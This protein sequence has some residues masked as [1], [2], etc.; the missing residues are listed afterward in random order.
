MS[1]DL[2]VVRH[3]GSEL[4][5][6]I[7]DD[8]DRA[9]TEELA[10]YIVPPR[11]KIVQALSDDSLKEL[12]GEGALVAAPTN[13]VLAKVG[14]KVPFV[15]VLFWPSWLVWNPRNAGDLPM[16][17]EETRDP[18]SEIAAICRDPQR[19]N[20]V[21]CPEFPDKMLRYQEHLNYLVILPGV[22][23]HM[24]FALSFARTQHRA[25]SNLAALIR[26]RN[27][28][29]YAGGYTMHTVR[30]EN[31]EGRWFGFAIENAGWVEDP[32]L[33]QSLKEMHEEL[34]TQ[35]ENVKVEFD[36]DENGVVDGAVVDSEPAF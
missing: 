27:K 13:I 21:S 15:P 28:P 29:I 35:L 5:A 33:Y 16:V 32:E 22:S 23:M 17:R 25:G 1:E 36:E 24:V 12:A 19:R 31:S 10:Q 4:P 30:Q 20:A 18:Q 7:A 2:S 6:H 11:V 3:F 8:K 34:A 26:M 14:V 9:G